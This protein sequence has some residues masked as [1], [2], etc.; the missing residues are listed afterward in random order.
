MQ[1]VG[2]TPHGGLLRSAHN[3]IEPEICRYG[4]T[5]TAACLETNVCRALGGDRVVPRCIVDRQ[6]LTQL[7]VHPIPEVGNGL[8]ASK[9]PGQHPAV[10]GYGAVNADTHGSNKPVPPDNG[11]SIIHAA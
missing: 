2:I 5:A 10:A 11:K 8:I 6:R 1:L 9:R 7:A 3:S 4:V